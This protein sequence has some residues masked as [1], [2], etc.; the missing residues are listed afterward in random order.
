M[1]NLQKPEAIIFDFDDTLVD[2]KPII[3]KALYATFANFSID[4]G[5][6]KGKNIDINRSLKDYFQEIFTDNLEEA[7]EVF[8]K[9]YDNFANELKI[10]DNAEQVLN[11]LQINKV[12][13]SIVSN[14]NGQR[15]RNEINNKLSWGHF[16]ES[17]IGSGDAKE[18][19]PSA[20]PA[21]KALQ[22]LKLADYKNVWLIG[23]SMVD[24]MTARNLGCIGI[25]FNPS[26]KAEE[27][28]FI[29]H[30]QVINHSELLKF[31]KEIYV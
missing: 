24:L 19:K 10:I 1:N 27:K 5:I 25:L 3:E 9:N 16:F 26:K 17:I 12:R 18:D 31:L 14:K 15:L 21:K 6:I 20:E 2:T 30:Y 29:E 22:H 7:R 13:M 23:D 4:D 28:E 11:F 8:Y